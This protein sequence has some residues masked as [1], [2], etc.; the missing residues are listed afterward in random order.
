[1]IF[2][3]T[4]FKLKKSNVSFEAKATLLE[5]KLEKL[6]EASEN[7]LP[8]SEIFILGVTDYLKTVLPI[9]NVVG[10]LI[11]HRDQLDEIIDRLSQV[12]EGMPPT[13]FTPPNLIVNRNQSENDVVHSQSELL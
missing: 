4:Y 6:Q 5:K 12:S 1:L 7:D 11:R 10:D 13:R 9:P 2:F 8:V 3:V